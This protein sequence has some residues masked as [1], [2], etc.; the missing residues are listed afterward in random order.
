MKK[1]VCKN[2][3]VSPDMEDLIKDQSSR[4]NMAETTRICSDFLNCSMARNLET[5]TDGRI[6]AGQW[7]YL[8]DAIIPISEHITDDDEITEE[9]FNQRLWFGEFNA[10]NRLVLMAPEDPRVKSRVWACL[11]LM[12]KSIVDYTRGLWGEFK[13][14]KP[15]G[16]PHP[17]AL[18]VQA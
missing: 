8:I 4:G 6:P 11:E 2:L 15:K 10:V 18:E 9:E 12:P 3:R 13:Q 5:A 16:L 1:T 17:D 14:P 7:Y